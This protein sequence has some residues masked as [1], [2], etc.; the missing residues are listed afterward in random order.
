MK[1]KRSRMSDN[2]VARRT[3]EVRAGKRAR[4]ECVVCSDVT[5]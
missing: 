1:E 4:G 2:E 3:N 5:F